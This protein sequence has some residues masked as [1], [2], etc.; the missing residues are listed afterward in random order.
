MTEC[1]RCREGFSIWDASG[2]KPCYYIVDDN[3]KPEKHGCFYIAK[4]K[5]FNSAL[6]Y[7]NLEF[8]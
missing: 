3:Y 1:W 2:S 7:L 8:L 5:T 6:H 4:F